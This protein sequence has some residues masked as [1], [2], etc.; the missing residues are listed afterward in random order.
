MT[1]PGPKRNPPARE[2]DG[3]GPEVNQSGKQV[4]RDG[5][6]GIGRDQRGQ[7][8]PKDKERAQS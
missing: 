2:R 5:D 3:S 6:Q 4:E 8:Q 7:D 1:K